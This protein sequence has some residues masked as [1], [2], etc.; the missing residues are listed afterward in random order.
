MMAAQAGN[1]ILISWIVFIVVWL[2]AALKVKPVETKENRASNVVR[3]VVALFGVALL[4]GWNSGLRRLDTR[5]IPLSSTTVLVGLVM[6]VAGICLAFWARYHLGQNWGMTGT[7]RV[8]HEWV[9]TGPYA[10]IRHPIYVGIGVALGG[11]ALEMGRWGA[12]V[13]VVIIILTFWS[14]ARA[15]SSFLAGRFGD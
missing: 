7:V 15:E 13:G 14:R 10:F 1:V 5:F 6:T 11:T 2:I 8:G 3:R 9:R 4:F 12:M